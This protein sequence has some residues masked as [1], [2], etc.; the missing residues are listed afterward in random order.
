MAVYELCKMRYQFQ[1]NFKKGNLALELF[2]SGQ[3]KLSFIKHHLFILTD[4]LVSE[5][6]KTNE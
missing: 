1:S 4:P 3:T 2:P 5:N 6:N